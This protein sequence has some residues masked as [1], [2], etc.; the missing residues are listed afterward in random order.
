MTLFVKKSGFCHCQPFA[1]F[2]KYNNT[3]TNETMQQYEQTENVRIKTEP[4]DLDENE[5]S[6]LDT[7]ADHDYNL[8]NDQMDF[9]T[10][11]RTTVFDYLIDR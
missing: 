1:G 7:S 3:A 9:N 2:K 8:S 11:A 6:N 5:S 10:C 4:E